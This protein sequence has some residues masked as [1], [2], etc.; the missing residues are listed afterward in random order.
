MTE[1]HGDDE[2]GAPDDAP[3]LFA[4]VEPLPGG[5]VRFAKGPVERLLLGDLLDELENGL[6]TQDPSTKRLFPPAYPDDEE[7]EAEYRAMLHDELADG[8]RSRIARIRA[9]LERDELTTEEVDAWVGVLNDIRLT[10]GTELDVA[11]DEGL[12]DE[13]DP[14]HTPFVR[15]IYLGWLQ[16]QFVDAAAASLPDDVA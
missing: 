10:L 6:D 15:Y 3:I 14:R 4:R 5:G 13:D 2:E 7:A 9:T 8:R 1:A 12:P 11:Q 16:E